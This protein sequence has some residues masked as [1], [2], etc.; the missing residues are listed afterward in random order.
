MS[1][2]PEPGVN[3]FTASSRDAPAP[4][5]ASLAQVLEAHG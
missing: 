5:G 2:A 3:P 4:G 1:S